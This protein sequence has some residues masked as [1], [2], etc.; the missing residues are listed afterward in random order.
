MAHF[1]FPLN[2]RNL[3]SSKTTLLLGDI[4]VQSL[5]LLVE[6]KNFHTCAN[7]SVHSQLSS[8]IRL[9][10]S[11]FMNIWQCATHYCGRMLK[12]FRPA[13][14]TALLGFSNSTWQPSSIAPFDSKCFSLGFN[15][16][17]TLLLHF[18]STKGRLYW[19]TANYH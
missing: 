10:F 1:G 12:C 18:F 11:H 2:C 7:L 6:K 5:S 16:D 15:L 17:V 13:I 3:Y 9:L 4:T 8:A 14:V 19:L